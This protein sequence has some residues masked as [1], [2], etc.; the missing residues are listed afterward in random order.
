MWKGSEASNVSS[1]TQPYKPAELIGTD[2]HQNIFFITLSTSLILY[3]LMVL[4]SLLDLTSARDLFTVL[5]GA[6]N[7]FVG[8]AFFLK[9]EIPRNFGFVTLAIASVLYGMMNEIDS[10]TDDFTLSYFS[11]P[12]LLSILAGTFFVTQGET[13]KDVR[14]ILLSGF[15]FALSVAL[16]GVY[17]TVIYN[18]FSIMAALFALAAAIFFLRGQ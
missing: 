7:I 9:K 8:V 4:T 14:F 18:V 12:A 11:I 5:L 6:A 1:P 15:L 16:I 17:S 3:A 2:G 13:R 10:F